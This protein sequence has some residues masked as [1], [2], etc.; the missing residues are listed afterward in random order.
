MGQARRISS[1][2][3]SSPGQAGKAVTCPRRCRLGFAAFDSE[4]NFILARVPEGEV[5][6]DIFEKLKQQDILIKCTDGA[7]PLLAKTL[8]FTVGAPEENTA[9]YSALEKVLAA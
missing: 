6:R 1:W 8:R 9:L 3:K 7:H 2:W 5:A 4:A